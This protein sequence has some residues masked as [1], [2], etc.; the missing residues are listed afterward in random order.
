VTTRSWCSGT[1]ELP[2]HL[3]LAN[4]IINCILIL[5]THFNGLRHNVF[6]ILWQSACCRHLNLD[7]VLDKSFQLNTFKLVIKEDHDFEDSL[8]VQAIPHKLV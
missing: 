8:W 6:Q 4:S 3:D 2:V 1:K 5:E 7:V